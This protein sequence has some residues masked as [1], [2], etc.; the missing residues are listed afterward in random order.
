[1]IRSVST[2]DYTRNS[3]K[4]VF[5]N[6]HGKRTEERFVG[7]NDKSDFIYLKK[8]NV[9]DQLIYLN[10]EEVSPY[11]ISGIHQYVYLKGRSPLYRMDISNGDTIIENYA[12]VNPVTRRLDLVNIQGRDTILKY[13]DNWKYVNDNNY[14]IKTIDIR[15]NGQ[16]SIVET[17]V[18]RFGRKLWQRTY[19]LSTQVNAQY[20][21]IIDT[22]RIDTMKYEYRNDT[23]LYKQTSLG[24]IVHEWTYDDDERLIREEWFEDGVSG[25]YKTWA[26]DDEGRVFHEEYVD[27][28][29]VEEQIKLNTERLTDY[30][31]K[32]YTRSG[33]L[34][35]FKKFTWEKTAF[36]S[37]LKKDEQSYKIE[38]R[39]IYPDESSDDYYVRIDT[40]HISSN[41]R[42]MYDQFNDLSLSVYSNSRIKVD[43]QTGLMVKKK[44]VLKRSVLSRDLNG[45]W[46]K[47]VSESLLYENEELTRSYSRS[48]RRE[49]TYY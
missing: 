15:R 39:Y 19:T 45:L 37:W 10:S 5:Y 49:I 36:G 24:S 27:D 32:R 38:S 35:S 4:M 2:H 13:P 34:K 14:V 41:N 12:R 20:F 31:V 8:Y 18:N 7:G 44:Q 3:I 1:M 17:P 25:Q 30:W 33:D 29:L 40:S 47:T 28:I 46:T 9:H 22:S 16:A 23:I 48:R 26:Y 21:E 42:Y 11:V 43:R 6:E